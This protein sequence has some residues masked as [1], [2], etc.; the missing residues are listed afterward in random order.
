[1][2]IEEG[3]DGTEDKWKRRYR[4]DDNYGKGI[5]YDSTHK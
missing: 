5:T 4:I 2:S 3:E 1:M